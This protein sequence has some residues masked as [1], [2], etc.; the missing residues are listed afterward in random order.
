MARKSN[1]AK[2]PKAPT[3]EMIAEAAESFPVIENIPAE[4][5]APVIEPEMQAE[6]EAELTAQES[7]ILDDLQ[8]INEPETVIVAEEPAETAPA[9]LTETEQNV[10]MNA[11]EDAEATPIDWNNQYGSW[12]S[13][14]PDDL[15][16]SRTSFE[17]TLA[18]IDDQVADTMAH[19]ISR[20]LSWREDF[21]KAKNPDNSSIQS[22]LKKCRKEMVS[23]RA[24]RVLVATGVDPSFM[25][26]VLHDG[27]RY[28]VYAI[29]KVADLV[30]GASEGLVRNAINIA[31]MRSLFA[32]RAAGIEFTGELAKA[33]ASDKIHVPI[34]IKRHLFRHTVSSSTAPTQ[35]SSTMQA[36]V[37]L[38][39]V[40]AEGSVK[41]PVYIPTEA[42][43]TAHFR[44]RVEIKVVEPEA[45][46]A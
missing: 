18:A 30:K 15:P 29:G 8:G 25:N 16:T 7:E 14:V 23:K 45:V 22:T 43:I 17:E 20:E 44:E 32:C 4:E 40:K 21:E 12:S 37:T 35:A 6:H 9:E 10:L 11:L 36:L 31:C 13:T 42:P 33:A 24:A 1:K 26:R 41:R 5:T 3:V 28:N 38:G 46:A 27:S 34:A 19:A 2:A 39:V